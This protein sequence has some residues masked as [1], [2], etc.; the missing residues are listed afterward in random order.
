MRQVGRAFARQP[1]GGENAPY[2]VERYLMPS[3]GVVS[4]LHRYT[5]VA[6]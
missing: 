1:K 5:S 4:P 2:R 3:S 6:S